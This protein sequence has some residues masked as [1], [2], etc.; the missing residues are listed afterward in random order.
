[1][2]RSPWGSGVGIGRFSRAGR[3]VMLLHRPGDDHAAEAIV[4][5]RGFEDLPELLEAANGDAA[6]V[7]RGTE[8]SVASHDLLSPAARPRK[9]ICVGQNYL[10]HVEEGGRPAPPAHPD[11]FAKWDNTLAGP[12]AALPLPPESDQI[13][14]ESELAIVVGRRCRRLAADEVPSVVFGYAAAND[15]SV[16]DFQFHT[17][18]RTA[19]KAWDSLTPIGPV[20]VP[21]SALG[22][23]E[24]D[25]RI[26]GKLNGDV[27]QDDRTS[28]MLFGVTDLLVY[29]T[30]FM[31]L[32]PGDL[33]LTG[34]PAGVGAVR[35]PPLYL[36][37]GD[38]FEVTL[39]GIGSLRNTFR[40][41]QMA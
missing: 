6:A 9:I 29:I 30:T 34:T 39:E 1:M 28:S 38:T 22:G 10:A 4:D 33:V 36:R 27:V 17:G 5:G 21:A 23:V 25:L 3:P 13:D 20:V 7:E 40:T 2:V 15:G 35:T 12:F 8:L 32:E 24:P 16:R 26:T 14:F 19:G 41:E 31:T 11:L 37:D 18:Q